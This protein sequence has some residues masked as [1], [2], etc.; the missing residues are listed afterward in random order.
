VKVQIKKRYTD[1]V[2][3][4]CELDASL[5]AESHSV[6]LGAA[7]KLAIIARA[8]LAGADLAGANLAR[9]NL[10]GANL[11]DA[12]LARANLAGANL[13]AANLA[14]ADLADAYL[15]GANLADANLAGADLA[16]AY[17]AGANLARA[18]LADANLARAYL[19]DANLAGANLA[20]A[21][22]AGA[23][24]AESA[25]ARTIIVP[26][27]ELIV[28]KKCDGPTRETVIVKCSVPREA[29]RSN[30]ASRKCRFEFVDVLECHGAEYGISKHDGSTEYRV[31][32]RV[33]CDRWDEDRWNEC[34]GGIHAFL[35]RIE[36]EEY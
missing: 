31:G 23:K 35:T 9:A 19:A 29:R 36:A 21:N 26:E 4:E 3:F 11:A 6:R 13:A 22:L 15:A 24:N 30:A 28:W 8:D 10:A 34:S 25:L 27:G 2:Q 17:L 14:G 32:Q 18:Y 5:E 16:D 20:D 33:T 12:N 7:V 1:A